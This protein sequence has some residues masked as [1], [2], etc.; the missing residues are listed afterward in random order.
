[1][2]VE[3]VVLVILSV[4]AEPGYGME[5]EPQIGLALGAGA[6]RGLAHIGVLKALEENGIQVDYIAGTSMGAVIGSLYAAGY[7]AAQIENIVRS[8][9]WQE[10]FSGRPERPLVPLAQ[11]VDMTPPIVRVGL[12]R[13][14]IRLPQAIDSDY[15][16][17]RLLTEF[18]AGPGFKAERDFDRLPVPFRAV[19]ADL[20]TGERVILSQGSLDRR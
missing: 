6:A 9:R 1:M 11:R 17:N 7:S 12:D 18:L 19:A 14:D 10:I 4:L 5:E 20:A 13:W 8:I 15:R 16:I 3:V 2:R